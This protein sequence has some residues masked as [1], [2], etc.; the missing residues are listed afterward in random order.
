[1]RNNCEYTV[2]GSAERGT[3]PFDYPSNFSAGNG[4]IFMHYSTGYIFRREARRVRQISS[5]GV[6]TSTTY[7]KEMSKSKLNQYDYLLLWPLICNGK[8]E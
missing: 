5:P 3:V 4:E 7:Y 8:N 6:S 1:M 2:P